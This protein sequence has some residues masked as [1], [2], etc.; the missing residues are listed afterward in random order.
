MPA[1]N[2]KLVKMLEKMR[3]ALKMSVYEAGP[4]GYSLAR[5]LQ[6]A[7]LPIKVIVA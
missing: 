2:K 3:I 4:T 6:K 7:S 5:R 1:D